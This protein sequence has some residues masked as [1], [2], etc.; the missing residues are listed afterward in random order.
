MRQGFFRLSKIYH[1]IN[2]MKK[3]N[4]QRN[5]Q[6]LKEGHVAFLLFLFGFGNYY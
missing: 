6:V 1:Y 4:A 2:R 5:S 3:D